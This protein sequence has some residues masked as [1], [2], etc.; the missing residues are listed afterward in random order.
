MK[1]AWFTSGGLDIKPTDVILEGR[2][3]AFVS[4]KSGRFSCQKSL[5]KQTK[6]RVKTLP[7][8][9]CTCRLCFSEIAISQL[10]RQNFLTEKQFHRENP[11]SV[12][13]FTGWNP[14]F[15]L[16]QDFALSR[17]KILFGRAVWWCRWCHSQKNS[18]RSILLLQKIS[19]F[20]SEA[21]HNQ[22]NWKLLQKVIS[23]Q[24]QLALLREMFARNLAQDLFQEHSEKSEDPFP[25]KSCVTG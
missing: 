18:Q 24:S 19:G 7:K 12:C 3:S 6:P 16:K 8:C 9:I 20:S 10:M 25:Q 2:K 4:S 21:S 23:P 22:E 17:V 1:K 11:D 5:R 13:F 15:F 14:V